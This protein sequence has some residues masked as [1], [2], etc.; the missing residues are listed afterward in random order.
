VPDPAIFIVGVY[1]PD[2][3]EAVYREQW[4]VTGTDGR[5]QEHF[6]RLVLIEAVVTNVDD[7]FKLKHFGQTLDHPMFP[8]QFQC[9]YDEALLSAEGNCV[10]DR[11]MNCVFGT[12][13]LRLAFYLHFYDAERPLDWT[14]EKVEC[15]PLNP[16]LNDSKLSCHTAPATSLNRCFGGASPLAPEFY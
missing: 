10:I 3:P 11:S 14:Y 6:G 1:K 12:G 2:I 16:S 8:P 4:K 13:S 7:K 9:A 5:T 15:P